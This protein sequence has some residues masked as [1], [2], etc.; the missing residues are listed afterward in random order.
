M[1]SS[2]VPASPAEGKK[3]PKK[4]MVELFFLCWRKGMGEYSSIPYSPHYTC[5]A[6]KTILTQPQSR[7][8]IPV[9]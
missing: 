4:G 3:T 1:A 9:I 7:D 5:N 6:T 2:K 8:S